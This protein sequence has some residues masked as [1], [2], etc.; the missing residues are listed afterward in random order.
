MGGLIFGEAINKYTL[1]YPDV[2]LNLICEE[3]DNLLI[4]LQNKEI[5]IVFAKKYGTEVPSGLKFIRVGYM[6]D[7]FIIN[8]KSELVNQ[9]LTFDNLKGNEAR[10]I[11]RVISNYSKALSL[12]E[13]YDHKKVM[14]ILMIK[15]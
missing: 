13:D 4:K 10:E 12:F 7:A 9:I 11:I 14:E 1:E 3:I 5:D 15:R 6:H 8:K 2:N